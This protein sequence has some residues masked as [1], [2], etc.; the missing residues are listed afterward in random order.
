M[1][2]AMRDSVTVS[3]S[4]DRIGTCRRSPSDRLVDRSA[5]L[6]RISEKLVASETS[7]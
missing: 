7:S 5:S 1:A 4:L 6:G 2:M 3:M